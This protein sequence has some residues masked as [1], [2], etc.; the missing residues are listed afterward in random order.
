MCVGGRMDGGR[1][2]GGMCVSVM[3][4][5]GD[6]VVCVCGGGGGGPAQVN[7]GGDGGG[8]CQLWGNGG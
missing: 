5:C 8:S 4:V 6:C 7:E 1:G 2:G 3:Q